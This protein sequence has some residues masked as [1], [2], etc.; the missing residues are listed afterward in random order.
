MAARIETS[1]QRRSEPDKTETS[2]V[3]AERIRHQRSRGDSLAALQGRRI[4]ITVDRVL[5]ARGKM[6]KNQANWPADCLVTEMLQW[7]PT[8]RRGKFFASCFSRSQTPSL[9][10]DFGDSVQSPY[11]QSGTQ[12]FWWICCTKKRSRMNGGG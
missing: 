2:E 9:R 6:M 7:L 3:Q 5:G 4:Q 12:R 11:F 1:G 8:Q 10:R